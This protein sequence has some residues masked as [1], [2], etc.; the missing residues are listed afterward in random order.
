MKKKF[1][2]YDAYIF[3]LDGTIYTSDKII[4]GSNSVVNHIQ[5]LNKK[6]I[7][8]SNKTTGTAT[9]YYNFLIGNKFELEKNQ[10]VNATEI[11]KNYIVEN[12]KNE[13]FYAIG[14]HKFVAEIESCKAEFC[15]N[16]NEIKFVIVTLD[17]TFNFEKLEIAA[18]AIENG[19][20]FYAANIDATCP[21]ENGEIWDAGATILALEKRTHRKLEKHFGKPSQFMIAEIKKRLDMDLRNCLI[22]GDRLETDIA[23]GNNFGI[24]TALVNTGVNNFSNGNA[25]IKP[26]Y[27]INSVVDL[28]K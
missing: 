23:M 16:P 14:E 11:I 6:V 27:S 18:K 9:D 22:I 15:E 28:I 1:N 25:H 20:H 12:H 24:D 10:V 2:R 3:D 5:T 13:K 21:V 19:A 4:A 26:T 8:I 17:R 7:F